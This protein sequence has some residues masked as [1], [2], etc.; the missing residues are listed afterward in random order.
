MSPVTHATPATPR[1]SRLLG[2]AL[3]VPDAFA[4]E[5]L[6]PA[7]FAGVARARPRAEAVAWGG[8]RLSYAELDARANRLAR[9]LQGVGVRP[10][11]RVGLSLER[12]AGVVTAML[13]VLKA[14]ASYVPLDPA[15][16]AERRA[17]MRRDAG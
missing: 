15:Y 4:R 6:L 13:A 10:G 2:D 1:V 14:G 3:D 11:E 17:F 12:S 8:E 9:H 7:L 16:P 5:V